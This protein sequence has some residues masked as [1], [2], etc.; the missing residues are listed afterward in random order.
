MR[1]LPDRIEL[2]K[3]NYHEKLLASAALDLRFPGRLTLLCRVQGNAVSVF[4]IE[5]QAEIPLISSVDPMAVPCGRTGI[6]A[7]GDGIG[8]AALRIETLE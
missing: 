2:L 4:R 1:V 8:F 5:E 3:Q 7:S 6:D